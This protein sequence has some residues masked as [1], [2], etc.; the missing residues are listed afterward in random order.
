MT[1]PGTASDMMSPIIGSGKP[2]GSA[3]AS[4]GGSRTMKARLRSATARASLTTPGSQ[5]PGVSNRL[6][7]EILSSAWSG[8]KAVEKSPGEYVVNGA[9]GSWSSS[10]V[11][12]SAEGHDVG[13]APPPGG[14]T[15][16]SED[17]GLATVPIR[18]S[19]VLF[20]SAAGGA[21]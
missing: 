2:V 3:T 20:A 12:P 11:G 17:T 1:R 4:A 7:T 10:G 21:G 15:V 5:M 18:F 13:Y 8:S 9:G 19:S 16:T 6:K 14:A